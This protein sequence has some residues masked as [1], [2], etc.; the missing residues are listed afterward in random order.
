MIFSLFFFRKNHQWTPDQS[1]SQIKTGGNDWKPMKTTSN[2]F[3]APMVVPVT[4]TMATPMWN[5]VASGGANPM[6]STSGLAQ[7]NWNNPF[8]AQ[9]TMTQQPLFNPSM[10]PIRPIQ[11]QIRPTTTSS[12]NNPFGF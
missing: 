3:P 6:M 5:P 10:Q 11:Q 9:P 7:P 2:G 12:T 4:T 8:V 1:Q